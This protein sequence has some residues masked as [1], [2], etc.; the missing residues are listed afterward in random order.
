MTEHATAAGTGTEDVESFRLRARAWLAEHMPRLNPEE[1]GSMEAVFARGDA[2][3]P[4]ARELQR[5]LYDGGFAGICF[6]KEYGGLGLTRAHQR[7]FNEECAGYEMPLAL[8]ARPTTST[9]ASWWPRRTRS[10]A[11]SSS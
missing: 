5:K 6:P 9:Y 7:A 11:S 2:I 8:N 4:R 10:P 3:W 1:D